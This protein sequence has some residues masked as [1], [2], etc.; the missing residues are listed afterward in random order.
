MTYKKKKS[1]LVPGKKLEIF[2]LLV[3]AAEIFKAVHQIFFK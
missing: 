2:L 1:N 3:N